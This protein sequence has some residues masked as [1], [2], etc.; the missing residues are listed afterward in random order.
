MRDIE[1][2]LRRLGETTRADGAFPTL[3]PRVE[4]RVKRRRLAT[5][6]TSLVVAAALAFGGAVAVGAFE[7]PRQI[8][9]A[10]GTNEVLIDYN[11]AGGLAREDVR[12]T[13]R[14]DGSASVTIVEAGEPTTSAH[15]LSA[16][17]LRGL[18]AAVDAVDWPTAAA[19]RRSG[20]ALAT[21]FELRHDGYVVMGW[22]R[23]GP[24]EVI[25][26]I[27]YL[28]ALV[29]AL[30]PPEAKLSCADRIDFVPTYLPEGWVDR[31]QPGRGSGLEA[32][33]ALGHYG[34]DADAGTR[35]KALGG[36]ADLLEGRSPY[37]QTNSREIEV[38][39]APASLGDIHEGYSV[40]FPHHDC[41]LTLVGYG[42]SR[43]EL[44]RFAEELRQDDPDSGR[45]D[46][47]SAAIWPK[48]TS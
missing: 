30:A 29:G 13:V 9:P 27:G 31:L 24:R 25:S 48:D 33:E 37:R 32:P 7:P 28:D 10:D 46:D 42:V 17:D 6:A 3:P 47:R 26:L 38:L 8:A 5:V 35:T 11:R 4:R 19:E 2:R 45:S 43:G 16:A 15:E 40:E 14:A 23:S 34:N 20:L 41:D 12:L 1:A 36:F 18:A 44:A 39:G 21:R 22:D